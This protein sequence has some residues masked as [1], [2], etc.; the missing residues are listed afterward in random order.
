MVI[1]KVPFQKLSLLVAFD[2]LTF[3]CHFDVLNKVIIKTPSQC[4]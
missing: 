2:L 3:T 1:K 4:H